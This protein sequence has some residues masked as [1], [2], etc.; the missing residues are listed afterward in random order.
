MYIYE[1]QYHSLT[2][3]V[4]APSSNYAVGM[5]EFPLSDVEF[6]KLGVVTADVAHQECEARIVM[7]TGG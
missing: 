1:I 4:I 7:V 3:V 6:K 5:L 2:A